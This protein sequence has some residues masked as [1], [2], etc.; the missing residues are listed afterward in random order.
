MSQDGEALKMIQK[1]PSSVEKVV[2]VE[3]EEHIDQDKNLDILNPVDAN[4]HEARSAII[5]VFDYDDNIIE[6]DQSDDNNDNEKITIVTP[7]YVIKQFDINDI[8][9]YTYHGFKKF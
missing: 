4:G 7:K 2:D 3:D 1:M 8:H 9:N 5:D 6:N